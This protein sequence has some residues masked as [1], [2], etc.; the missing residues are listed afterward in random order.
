MNIIVLHPFASET[1][2]A[3]HTVYTAVLCVKKHTAVCVHTFGHTSYSIHIYY[4]YLFSL[5][6]EQHQ[7]EHTVYKV[8]CVKKTHGCLCTHSVSYKLERG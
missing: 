7:V 3:E 2:S 6:V 5:S 4:L 8:P 1:L